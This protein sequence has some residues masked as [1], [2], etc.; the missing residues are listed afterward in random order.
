MPFS[1][2]DESVSLC[3]VISQDYTVGPFVEN[4]RDRLEV[5]LPCS[6]PNLELKVELVE[7]DDER[8]KFD[9]NCDLMLKFE[10]ISGDSVH[11]TTL[12]H[13]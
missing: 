8:A 7:L 2:I 1:Q 6:V 13:T 12:S 10:I 9:S 11:K 5:F 4:P 3:N